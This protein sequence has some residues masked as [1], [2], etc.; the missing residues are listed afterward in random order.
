MSQSGAQPTELYPNLDDRKL[1]SIFD[2]LFCN[3]FSLVPYGTNWV[4]YE[5]YLVPCTY[6]SIRNVFIQGKKL[7]LYETIQF[8]AHTFTGK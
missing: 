1:L 4:Q 8:S 3:V 2:E 7:I 5:L 6:G